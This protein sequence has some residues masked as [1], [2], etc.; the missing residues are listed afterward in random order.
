MAQW[1]VALD[2]DDRNGGGDQP[3]FIRL[4]RAISDDVRRGRLKPGDALPGSRSLARTLGVHRNTVL[5][6]YAELAA[7]GWISTEAAA[8]TFVSHALPDVEAQPRRRTTTAALGFELQP[9]TGPREPRE[10]R[11]DFVP[12][13]EVLA[14][15][16]GIPDVRLVPTASLAR[17]YRRALKRGGPALLGYGDAR[18]HARLRSALGDMLSA[19]RGVAADGESLMVT[20]GS[21]LALDLV[22]RT[23]LEPGDVVAVEALGYRPAWSALAATGARVVPV[24]VDEHGLDVDALE[25]LAAR[26]RLRAIYVTP[27]HQYPTTVMLDAGR[28]LRLLELARAR[29]IAVIEDDYDFEFHYEGRP[30]L[31][32]AAAD[33]NAVVVY[34]GTLSKILAPALRLG[35]VVAP[36]PLIERLAEQRLCIDRQGDQVVE[37]AVAELIE[38]GELQRHVRRMKR[39]YQA[40]RDLLVARL[41]K[42]LG[43]ALEFAVP[44]GGMALWARTD[45][46]IDVDAWAVRAL[47][48]GVLFNPAARFAFDGKPRPALRLGFAALDESELDEGVRRMAAALRG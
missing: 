46:A 8:R 15:S 11:R 6:A 42:R 10:A 43:G 37:C 27:H 14:M 48:R 35:F 29:R 18:G 24:A 33:R 13:P 12:P 41:H 21:Q 7:E 34:V 38:D 28:R 45:D 4:A 3:I 44:A 23:L 26:E 9:R 16:G 20:R 5:A 40:R 2:L 25:A 47:A 19:L 30:V 1:Q 22:A 36:P 17:A 31:P 39:I 32:L